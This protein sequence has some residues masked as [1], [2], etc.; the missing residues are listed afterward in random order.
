MC[1]LILGKDNVSYNLTVLHLTINENRFSQSLE[2]K[3]ELIYN[4]YYIYLYINIYSIYYNVFFSF[5]A[6]SNFINCKM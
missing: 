4:I 1:L 2:S 6:F 3:D 5:I